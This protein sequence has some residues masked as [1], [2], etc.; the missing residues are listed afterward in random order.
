MSRAKQHAKGDLGLYNLYA[1]SEMADLKS[2]PSMV[3]NINFIDLC[4]PVVELNHNSFW[5][6]PFSRHGPSRAALPSP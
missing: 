6:N 1:L 2:L 5:W 4:E 3:N